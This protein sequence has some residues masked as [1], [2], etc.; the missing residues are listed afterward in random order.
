M[1]KSPWAQPTCHLIREAVGGHPTG[2]HSCVQI[3]SVVTPTEKYLPLSNS[4]PLL[5]TCW[6][7]GCPCCWNVSSMIP[8]D[9]PVSL[10]ILS[11]K[12]CPAHSR[13]T[14]NIFWKF[15]LNALHHQPAF[16]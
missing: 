14:I 7:T 6:L 9:I 4:V 5:L 16:Q 15:L 13:C 11:L 8:G 10:N 12:Q 2:S 1:N 3:P